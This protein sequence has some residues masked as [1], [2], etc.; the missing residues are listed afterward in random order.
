MRTAAVVGSGP[1]GLVAAAYLARAGWD[2]TVFEAADQL[3]GGTTS[4]ELAL[5]GA[6]SDVCSAVHPLGIASPALRNLPLEEHGLTWVHPEIPFG[7]TI[8]GGEA[9]LVHRSVDATADGL[10]VDAAAYRSLMEPL[11]RHADSLVD[12]VLVRSAGAFLEGADQAVALTRFGTAATR[13]ARW[14]ANRFEGDRAR[15]VV[16]GLAAHGVMPLDRPVTAGVGLM[17]GVLAHSVGWPVARGGSQNIADALV[18]VGRAEGVTYEVGHTVED[19]GELDGFDA[20]LADISPSALDRIAGGRLTAQQRKPLLRFAHGPGVC[21]VDWVI[22]GPIPWTDERLTRAGTVH[23][24]GTFEQVARAEAEVTEGVHPRWPYVLLAQQ[25]LID[26]TRLSGSL[27]PGTQV[28]WAYCHVPSG[29]NLDMSER[30]AAVVEDSAPGF[31][32]RILAAD[33]RT[34]VDMQQHNAN[35]VGGDITGG[36]ADL[37]GQLVRPFASPTPWRTPLE[38]VY[39]CS[40]STPPGAGVHGMCGWHA[41]R[42]ALADL[43]R[44]LPGRSVLRK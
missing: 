16:A 36:V 14:L 5:P 2:V 43:D 20:V 29:S 33:V 9:V 34:A 17:L 15:A 21:K 40:A 19:L 3:G 10:G 42:T 25:S 18:S 31:A 13:S 30:I 27:P 44:P 35:Y 1:N 28:V 41:A 38:G 26:P 11:V 24:G 37:R 12:S 4:A 39:L 7:H 23:L 32:S 8:G 6:V 22:D